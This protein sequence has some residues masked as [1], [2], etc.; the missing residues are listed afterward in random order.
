M[1]LYINNVFVQNIDELSFDTN[2]MINRNISNILELK[3][4]TIV[5][6]K[7]LIL[8]NDINN[9]ND[10]LLFCLDGDVYQTCL[11]WKIF[12]KKI[13]DNMFIKHIDITLY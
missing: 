7:Y 5:K 10:N 8:P 4:N 11:P 9:Y 6:S 13:N 3:E 12:L 1:E 2:I